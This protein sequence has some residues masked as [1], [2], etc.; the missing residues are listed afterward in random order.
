MRKISKTRE[1]KETKI[2]LTIKLD[3][4]GEYQI[5][6]G[7][8]FINHMLEQFAYHSGFDVALDVKSLDNDSHHLI[9]DVAITMGSAIKEALSD[10][11]GINRYAKEI[12]PMDEAL[13]MSVIDISGRPFCKVDIDLKDEK[14]S[15]FET[16]LLAHFFNSLAQNIGM[17]LHIKLL[18]GY[19]T[20]HI[21]EAAFKATARALKDAVKINPE[22]I[23]EIP[24]TKGIL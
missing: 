17:S 24:S 22:K 23:N 20:H 21:I 11:K 19:D 15:D 9:E 7:V 4:K 3:G 10:K 6:T 14:T 1:T 16:V 13:I 18:E 5:S 2:G 8:N 12:L